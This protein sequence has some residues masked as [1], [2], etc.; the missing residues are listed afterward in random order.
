MTDPNKLNF[1][2]IV[3]KHS[4]TK[5]VDTLITEL[6]NN[7]LIENCKKNKFVEI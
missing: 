4:K 6:I 1:L 7:N 2:G 3:I 5:Y